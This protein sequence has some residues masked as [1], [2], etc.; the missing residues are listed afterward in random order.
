MKQVLFTAYYLQVVDEV[1]TVYRLLFAGG[2]WRANWESR[3]PNC[4]QSKEEVQHITHTPI[5]RD[6][7]YQI[8][9]GMYS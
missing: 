7:M 2:G 3:W 6:R 9:E 5:R 1:S 4:Q 8:A